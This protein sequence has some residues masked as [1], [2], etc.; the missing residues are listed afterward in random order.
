MSD[1]NDVKYRVFQEAGAQTPVNYAV[2]SELTHIPHDF[3]ECWNADAHK[4]D[5]FWNKKRQSTLQHLWF[6]NRKTNNQKR[7]STSLNFKERTKTVVKAS[8]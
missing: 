3:Y 6:G 8:E 4:T 7:F 1:S 5:N 2:L